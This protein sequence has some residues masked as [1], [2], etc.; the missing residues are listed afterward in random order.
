[1]CTHLKCRKWNRVNRVTRRNIA[2][3]IKRLKNTKLN[4]SEWGGRR[5]SGFFCFLNFCCRSFCGKTFFWVGNSVEETTFT[6]SPSHVWCLHYYLGCN[7]IHVRFHVYFRSTEHT[8]VSE[9][10]STTKNLSTIT[11]LDVEFKMSKLGWQSLPFFSNIF[12]TQTHKNAWRAKPKKVWL[13][14]RTIRI[15]NLCYT[16]TVKGV[17]FLSWVL[18]VIETKY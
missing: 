1:M 18:N 4:Q 12:H 6:C 7:A 14:L 10:D 16:K 5:Y 13:E 17:Q 8:Y 9:F 11:V 2:K 15:S 3:M